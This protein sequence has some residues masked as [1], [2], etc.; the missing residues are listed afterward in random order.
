MAQEQNDPTLIL[1]AYDLLAGTLYYLGEIEE[2]NNTRCVVFKS[3]AQEMYSLLPKRSTRAVIC[4]G[5]GR[6]R[7]AS[8]KD[9][10]LETL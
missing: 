5:G 6:S 2:R 10:L 1:G 3:G 9:R 8:R 4:L 7:V